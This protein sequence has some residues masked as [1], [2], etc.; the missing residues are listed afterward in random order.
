VQRPRRILVVRTDRLG[1]VVLATPLLRALRR[2]FPEA[3]VAALVRSYAQDLLLGNP[4]LDEVLVDDR[5]GAH[6]GKR[7]FLRLVS[8]LRRRRFDTALLLLPTSRTAW[9]LALA[10][11]R[12]R[13]GVGRK[14]YEV[15]TFMESVSRHKYVP[16]R[17]EADY[18]LDLGRRLGVRA[19]DG[20]EDLATEVFVADAER[21]AARQRLA[22]AGV[23]PGDRIVGVHAGHGGSSPNWE[24]SRYADLTARILARTGG[25]V[26]IALTGEEPAPSFP[27][28]PRL[29]DLRGSRPLR[30]LVADISQLDCLVSSSTGPMHIAAALRV[31]TVSLFCPLPACSNEL[32]GPRGNTAR[33]LLPPAGYCQGRCPGDPKRCRLEEIDV[34][35]VAGAVLAILA[36]ERAGEPAPDAASEH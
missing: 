28:H 27:L 8:D 6:A 29:L 13:I 3:R 33:V 32:W 16:L 7:G 21:A 36:S 10:G 35:T 2:T 25:G 18:C 14:F 1:D 24:A 9:A 26:R 23:R 5:A 22:S 15:A 20:P 30:Q 17:H 4:H 31:P 12:R 19:G 11:I 34:E